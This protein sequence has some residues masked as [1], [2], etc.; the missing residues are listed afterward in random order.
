M[1][2]KLIIFMLM[3]SLFLFSYRNHEV[4]GATNFNFN[5]TNL[6]SNLHVLETL[7][8]DINPNAKV[9]TFNIANTD[10]QLLL[11]S[12]LGVNATITFYSLTGGSGISSI[13]QLINYIPNS[14]I[15]KFYYYNFESD[16]TF[17]PL[18]FKIMIPTIFTGFAPG[19]FVNYMNTNSSYDERAPLKARF[20]VGL[21]FY[22]EIP[23]LD[24]IPFPPTDPTPPAGSIFYG[25][26]TF[27]GI[28]IEPG[29]V[30]SD[31][32]IDSNNIVYLYAIFQKQISTSTLAPSGL[33]GV[34][35]SL[36]TILLNTGFLN[37][38]GVLILY[39]T[40]IFL[41][42]LLA[43]R[44]SLTALVSILINILITGLFM[45]L[46]FLPL[47]ASIILIGFYIFAIISINKGGLIS[48]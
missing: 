33:G 40:S 4:Q 30:P 3:F 32:L 37:V 47:F 20:M 29:T 18:S 41:I 10:P 16:L 34:N 2:K 46:G 28:V 42:N 9:L 17:Q 36:D 35:S 23:F 12:R 6:F 21:N 24:K 13:K 14:D 25:W 7:F 27:N 5:Y 44:L 8:L 1:R 31:E 19:G 43:L 22:R 48:E 45:F 15:D 38:P 39:F 11:Y 26:R